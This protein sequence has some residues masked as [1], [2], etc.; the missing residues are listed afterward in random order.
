M[1]IQAAVNVLYCFV[2]MVNTTVELDDNYQNGN[3]HSDNYH[4]VPPVVYTIVI[5]THQHTAHT[6]AL[7]G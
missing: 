4:P 3:Y 7:I 5:S 6:S 1:T 2:T